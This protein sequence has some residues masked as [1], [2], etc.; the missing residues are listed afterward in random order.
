MLDTQDNYG[1]IGLVILGFLIGMFALLHKSVKQKVYIDTSLNLV[2]KDFH[3]VDTITADRSRWY[4]L[5][6]L[7]SQ[8]VVR[9]YFYKDKL[10]KP[11]KVINTL[12]PDDYF[13][14]DME[15]GINVVQ[16]HELGQ[17]PV[18]TKRVLLLKLKERK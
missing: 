15:N 2:D 18:K 4:Y 3:K 16:I 12:E 10:G 8:R 9:V 14:V 1:I 17:Y 6:S 7:D 5:K 11:Y 13:D